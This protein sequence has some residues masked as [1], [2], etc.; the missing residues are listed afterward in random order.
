MPHF[1]EQGQEEWVCQ[2]GAHVCTGRSTWVERGSDEAKTLGCHGSICDD[3]LAKA[4]YS[5]DEG[6][7]S[8]I[9]HCRRE[10]GLDGTALT[11]YINRHY[12]H[13]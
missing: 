3:C 9:E 8:I 13:G 4:G 6:P 1:N 7:L 2:R 5:I 11:E 12:G 10:S